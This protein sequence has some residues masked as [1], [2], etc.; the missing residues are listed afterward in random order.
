MSTSDIEMDAADRQKFARGGVFLLLGGLLVVAFA[1][2][3]VEATPSLYAGLVGAA[4][5]LVVAWY[6]SR[7]PVIRTI[8]FAPGVAA[9]GMALGDAI[10]GGTLGAGGVLV[11][12]G[13]IQL[14]TAGLLRRQ[15]Q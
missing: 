6:T 14:F 4:V 3:G 12:L 10:P 2:A 7:E 15:H 13:L 9:V 8:W 5:A 11:G 1:I